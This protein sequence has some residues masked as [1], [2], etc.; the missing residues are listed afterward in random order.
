MKEILYFDEE[1]VNSMLSQFGKGIIK[2]LQIEEND[3]ETT[4]NQ[5]MDDGRID[6]G[7]K[8][9]LKLTSGFLPGGEIS[10][11]GNGG[12]STG[13]S[14]GTSHTISEGQRDVIEKIFHDH[15][16]EL[17]IEKLRDK[18]GDISSITKKTEGEV[19]LFDNYYKFYDFELITKI[20]NSKIISKFLEFANDSTANLDEKKIRDFGK[21]IER[22]DSSKSFTKFEQDNY[23]ELLEQYLSLKAKEQAIEAFE[24]IN[25]LSSF[26]NDVISG[27][28][29]FKLN[30]VLV[31]GHKQ[32]MRITSE[33]L[34]FRTDSSK[35]KLTVLGRV[36]GEK[37]SKI[38][39]QDI[40]SKDF[41]V[42]DFDKVP[43][44]MLDL[45]LSA[46]EISTKGE[47][48]INPLAIYFEDWFKN[49]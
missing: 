23:T 29:I 22:Q 15:A 46:L 7:I 44:V 4:S 16:L 39:I 31:I 37:G 35:R 41:K 26:T 17:L 48:I 9:D 21:K 13:S 10:F 20:S 5:I 45:L 11:G 19:V 24:M 49:I 8:V 43:A 36:I 1:S 18:N 28:I 33:S 14:Y 42:S 2:S 34:V 38:S 32:N 40:F 12:G 30:D 3:Q 6:S 27:L 25:T 47:I